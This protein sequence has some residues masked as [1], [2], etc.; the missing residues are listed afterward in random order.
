MDK[1]LKKLLTRKNAALALIAVAVGGIV[2]W[3]LIK[4]ARD[5]QAQVF[6]R[7]ISIAQYNYEI[8]CRRG[9]CP[10]L[11][12]DGQQQAPEEA[13]AKLVKFGGL[14][15]DP[16]IAFH[17][18]PSAVPETGSSGFA[19]F[20]AYNSEGHKVYYFDSTVNGDID[21]LRANSTY[22]G[23]LK[24]VDSSIALF[25]Y[26]YTPGHRRRPAAVEKVPYP[27]NLAPDPED[28]SPG[29]LIVAKPAGYY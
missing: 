24:G 29:R 16:S 6:L 17:I 23:G 5:S 1:N 12:T 26:K 9:E 4:N 25:T 10:S 14:R 11:V 13:V 18:A 21:H 20:A 22:S 28:K 8:S 27:V 2:F 3:G 7:Q 15:L 19:A